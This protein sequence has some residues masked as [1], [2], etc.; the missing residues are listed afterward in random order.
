M[1]SEVATKD[2]RAASRRMSEVAKLLLQRMIDSGFFDCSGL[3][4]SLQGIFL[5]VCSSGG[6]SYQAQVSRLDELS[7]CI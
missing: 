1:K 4:T 5:F 7:K 3:F 6:G 2:H